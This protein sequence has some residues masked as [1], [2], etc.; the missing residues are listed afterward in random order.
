[1]SIYLVIYSV[2][3]TVRDHSP[4]T[5]TWRSFGGTE[6]WSNATKILSST[7]GCTVRWRVY[8]NNSLDYWSTNEIFRFTTTSSSP[9]RY[10]QLSTQGNCVNQEVTIE[11]TYDGN[12]I[13]ADIGIYYNNSRIESLSTGDDGITS[14]IPSLLEVI[15]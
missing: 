6:N 11:T 5:H 14:F 12:P 10:L 15:E 13:S 8:T 7:V 9:R 1:M 3:T 2:L 4:M